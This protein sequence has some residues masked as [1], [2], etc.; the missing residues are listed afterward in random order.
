MPIY[1]YEAAQPERSCARCATPCE[2][3]QG[4]REE[5]LDSCPYCGSPVRKV[6]SWGRGAVMEGG[7]EDALVKRV[8]GEYEKAGMWSHAAELADK[9][10]EKTRDK[11]LKTRALDNYEKAGYNTGVFEKH[12]T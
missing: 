2:V 10:S 3:L 5:P 8:V 7:E 11:A 12:N 1:E 9:H 4:L 6:I